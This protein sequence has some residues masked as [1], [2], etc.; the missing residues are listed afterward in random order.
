MRKFLTTATLLLASI[1]TMA[2]EKENRDANNKIVR[3]PYQTNRFGDNWFIQGGAGGSV[4]LGGQNGGEFGN[5]IRPV[6]DL[7]VGKWITPVFDGRIQYNYSPSMRQY[8]SSFNSPFNQWGG[9]LQKFNFSNLHGDA[10]FN[11]SAAIGG[12]REKRVYEVIPYLGAGWARVSYGDAPTKNEIAVNFGI[13]NKFRV[14]RGVDVNL[15]LRS[16]FAH[17]RMDMSSINNGNGIDVPIA[18]TAGVSIRLGHNKGFKRAPAAPDY[19]S[20]NSRIQT[21]ESNNSTLDAKAKQLAAELEAAKNR[22]PETITVEGED[23]VAASPVA[24]F[25][26]LG[27][28]TL[29]KKELTN[30]DFYVKN[31][32]KVDKNKKFTL[33]GSADRVTGSKEVNQRLSEQRMEYIYNLLVDKYGISQDR[34]LKKAEGDSNNRFSEPELNRTVII[35]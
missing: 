21:L 23:R 33:V 8:S 10:L 14:S 20:Y 17:G 35:E 26:G 34:L 6:F 27:K 12:Y 30:L 29:D 24:L 19:S 25:F 1:C 2:Q 7:S 16:T 13:I 3:G 15:E 4:Y 22:K 5:R 18:A 32:V 28:A 31:A 9:T 11:L